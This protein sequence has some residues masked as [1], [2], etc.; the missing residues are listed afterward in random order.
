MIISEIV[1]SNTSDII[2][3]HLSGECNTPELAE[4]AVMDRIP[5]VTDGAVKLY[6]ARQHEAFSISV[7]PPIFRNI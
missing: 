1:S 4:K 6:V 7:K 3:L 2:L 5:W